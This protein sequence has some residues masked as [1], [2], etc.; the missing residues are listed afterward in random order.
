M[1]LD[2]YLSGRYNRDLQE[3][4]SIELVLAD[5]VDTYV[6][7]FDEERGCWPYEIGSGNAKATESVGTAAMIVA[8]IGKLSQHCALRSDAGSEKLPNLTKKRSDRFNEVVEIAIKK[9]QS[10]FD[11]G[12]RI[13]SSTFGD[14]D[15]LTISHITELSR[16]LK[17]VSIAVPEEAREVIKRLLE[18]NPAVALPS[19]PSSSEK[20]SNLSWCVGSAFVALRVVRAGSDIGFD[21]R[22]T[23]YATF[24][25][26]RLHEQLSFSAIPDSR[27]DPAELAFCLEGLLLCARE[28]V[29]PVLFERVL[30]VLAA[31]QETS[32]YWRPNRPFIANSTGAI[33]LPLSVEGA[34]SLLNSVEIMDGNKLHGTFAGAALLMFQ[35]FWQWLRARKVEREVDLE[36]KSIHCVG[37][38]SEHINEPNVIH[39]WDTS[40]VVEFLVAFR[41][42]LQKQI[43]RETLILSGVKVEEPG[44]NLLWSEVAADFEPLAGAGPGKQVFV[45]IERDFVKPWTNGD[46]DRN[47][48]ALIY[49]PPGTGKTTVATSIAN[50]LGFRLLTITVSDFLGAG[51]ALVEA[52]AKAIFDML[53]AQSDCVI[54]FD[55]IDAFLLDRDSDHYDQQDTLFKFLTPGMLTKINNLRKAARSIFI[56]ATN[57]ENRIDPA[58]KRPG[59]IDSKYLLLLPDLEKRRAIIAR[60][61]KEKYKE[62]DL[63]DDSK[64]AE[65]AK[66]SLFLGYAEIRAALLQSGD[67]KEDKIAALLSM[68]RSSNLESYLRRAEKE[69]T[70]PETE[71][72][73]MVEL[74]SECPDTER[75][76]SIEA[77]I[78]A[79]KKIREFIEKSPQLKSALTDL[80][81][82]IPEPTAGTEN[83]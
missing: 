64:I 57:Y 52:R 3:I 43:A 7:V 62:S 47:C 48:S 42:L 51:G 11:G 17:G 54:F 83:G 80:G 29:D 1:T 78:V 66:A 61:L 70:F 31:T 33:T 20:I 82:N 25:E 13:T 23:K 34:N 8:A 27:F 76:A 71:F 36:G 16:A 12:Q 81:V 5:V 50:A 63:I 68:P 14:N 77:V 4:R 28:A 44:I 26:S 15:P 6:K 74:A 39:L 58:I 55:E 65:M 46:R 49:G 19:L 45:S 2:D 72:L 40:Q 53:E 24:F 30:K 10:R 67:N 22:N 60:I 35:R 75:N 32:A 56:I 21:C 38:H 9:L 37:W 41:H 18:E 59:R 73:G 69:T 79:G